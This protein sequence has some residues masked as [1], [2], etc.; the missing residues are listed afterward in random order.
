LCE[1]RFF[2]C[3]LRPTLTTTAIADT[4]YWLMLDAPEAF[5][6]ELDICLEGV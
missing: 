5:A 6:R 2:G 4:G 1:N 3:I